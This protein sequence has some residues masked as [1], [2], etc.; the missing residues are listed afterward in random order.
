LAEVAEQDQRVM[1]LTADLGY[2]AV[3][4]FSERFPH[5][6]INVGVAEQNLLGVATGLAEAGFV[7]FVYSIATFASLRAYE[8]VR[9]GPV[10]HQLPVRIVGVGGGFEYGTAGPSHHGL[11][12]LAIMRLQPG[13][14]VV[15][16]AD[17][18]QAVSALWATWDLQGPVYFRLG[19]DDRRIVPGLDG[20]FELGRLT[21]I[22]S[23]TDLLIVST[24]SISYDAACATRALAVDGI[25]VTHAIVSSFNPAPSG[26]LSALLPHF[27]SVLTVEAHYVN[28]GVGS[29][30][31]EVI[32]EAGIP[33]RLSRLAVRAQFDGLAGSEAYMNAANGLDQRSITEA[34][35]RLACAA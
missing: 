3:E 7:P 28:G 31:A 29:F 4:P 6:F 22:G 13:L 33:C 20:R 15:A 18:D 24:G 10:L 1:L 21:T 9:N 25:E 16:P 2:M 27:R 5:R 26:D 23:G 35:V 11:E 34:A 32:A 12:E 8:F 30:V 19:K 14:T 17:R